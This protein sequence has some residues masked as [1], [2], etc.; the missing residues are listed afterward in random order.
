[1]PVYMPFDSFIVVLRSFVCKLFK[2]P[3]KTN[4]FT[5]FYVNLKHYFI[6]LNITFSNREKNKLTKVGVVTNL[7]MLKCQITSLLA[8]TSR[9]TCVIYR[10]FCLLDFFDPNF[11][12]S[13]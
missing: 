12:D 1:M 2:M 10:I 11:S 4:F 6:V 5:F 9:S 8:F 7:D 3:K 13:Q